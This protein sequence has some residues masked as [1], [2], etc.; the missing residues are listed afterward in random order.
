MSNCPF[1]KAA[2]RAGAKYCHGCGRRVADHRFCSNRACRNFNQYLPDD[3]AYCPICG[4]QASVV[5]IASP[6]YNWVVYL[7]IV[8]IICVFVF[9]EEQDT[10]GHNSLSNGY[11]IETDD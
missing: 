11:N 5:Y 6:R 7:I 1:C 9:A 4:E 8:I 2:Y 10:N 3:E